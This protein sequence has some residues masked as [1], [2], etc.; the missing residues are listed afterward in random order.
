MFEFPLIRFDDKIWLEKMQSG[1]LYMRSSLYYQRIENDDVARG[2]PYDGSIPF[3]E[4]NRV[5]AAIS[6]KTVNNGRLVLFDRFIKCFYHCTESD[7]SHFGGNLWKLKLSE[8]AMDT[9]NGFKTNSAMLIFNPSAFIDQVLNMCSKEQKRAWYGDVQYVVEDDY[10][11][12]IRD[13]FSNPNECYK[14]PFY[15]NTRFSD[16][17]EYRICVQHPFDGID[18][19]SVWQDLPVSIADLSYTLDIGPIEDACIVSIE[20]LYKNGV[21]L[22]LQKEH[23]YVCED[24]IDAKD[25]E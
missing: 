19:E 15:K 16:Q 23:Y 18:T 12:L 9:M 22:D 5:A 24:S 25:A 7:F 3:P 2:D 21:L 11:K 4:M 1:E 13:I 10:S 17:K 20:N 6:G 8:K 14:L